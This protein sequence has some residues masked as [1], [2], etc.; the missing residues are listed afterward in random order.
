LNGYFD[1]LGDPVEAQVGEILK[2]MG[3]GLLAIFPLSN[4][5]ACTDLL[6]AIEDGRKRI[7]ELNV[8]TAEHGKP[9]LRYGVGVHVGDVMYGNIGSRKRLDF[10]AI[11]PAVNVASRLE[12]LTKLIKHPVLL[13]C[14]FVEICGVSFEFSDLGSHALRGLEKPVKVF[15]LVG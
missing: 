12:E 11:G 3:D 4:P 9:A 14:D 13:S 6:S 15:S 8:R 1:A 10:T 2:F 5:S 7:D